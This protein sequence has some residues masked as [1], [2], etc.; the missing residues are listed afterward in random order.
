[1]FLGEH[2]SENLTDL[3]NACQCPKAAAAASVLQAALTNS[4]P[5][6]LLIE[7]ARLFVGPFELGAP[8]YGSVYLEENGRLMGDSTLAVQRKYREAGLAQEIK[9]AP[10]HIALELEF[11]HYLCRMEAEALAKNLPEQAEEW[12][13]IEAEFLCRLLR[14]WVPTFCEKIRQGTATGFYRGLADCLDNFVAEIGL[15]PAIMPAQQES[16]LA[17][18]CRTAL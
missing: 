10:D 12:A 8:P 1:M 7:F 6:E 18:V 11:L 2:L 16:A 3:L 17:N 9:E 13:A 5:E 14:P 4:D 15:F